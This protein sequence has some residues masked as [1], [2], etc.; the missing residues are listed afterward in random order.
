METVFTFTELI[1]MLLVIQSLLFDILI[2]IDH[3]SEE[4][5]NRC[6]ERLRQ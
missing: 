6:L 3:L 2:K 1:N 4:R 5:E